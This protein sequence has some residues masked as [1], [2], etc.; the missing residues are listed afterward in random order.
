MGTVTLENRERSIQNTEKHKPE[1][2][3]VANKVKDLLNSMDPKPIW[4]I[5]AGTLMGAYRNGKM[6]PHDDDFD[7]GLLGDEDELDRVYDYLND[8]IN[9]R[10]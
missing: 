6:I 8:R 4:F 5:E 2:L 1:R 3:F 9:E 10:F 7:M